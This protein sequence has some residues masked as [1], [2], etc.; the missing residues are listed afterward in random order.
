MG[1]KQ[2]LK[3]SKALKV[4]HQDSTLGPDRAV[5]KQGKTALYGW[6]PLSPLLGTIFLYLNIPFGV[7]KAAEICYSVLGSV[8]WSSSWFRPVPR[9]TGHEIGPKWPVF[10]S[11][12]RDFGRR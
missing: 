7:D 8:P 9:E 3:L 6:D 1:P 4:V 11:K 2:G 10:A 5:R 12:A